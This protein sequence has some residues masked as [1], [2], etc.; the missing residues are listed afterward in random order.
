M[1]QNIK[2][3]GPEN[4]V[5]GKLLAEQ[6]I[7]SANDSITKILQTDAE[8][9]AIQ[10]LPHLAILLIGN[11]P[12]SELYVK[13]KSARAKE[14]GIETS[15]YKFP[16][17]TKQS[18]I[19]FLIDVLNDDENINGIMIQLPL[20]KNFGTDEILNRVAKIKDVDG[21][22]DNS[23]FYPATSLAI[24]ETL[25]TITQELG[26]KIAGKIA[27]VIGASKDV[28][29]PTQKL[30]TDEKV[31]STMVDKSWA[32]KD[33]IALC[34]KSDIVITATGNKFLVEKNWIKNGAIVIDVGIT[35][36]GTTETGKAILRGDA[37]IENIKTIASAITPVVG[38]IGPVTISML[39]KNVIT[40][41]QNQNKKLKQEK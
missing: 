7:A 22:A 13:T 27:T 5:N 41:Y 10:K 34:Q 4:I 15:L 24:M 9:N 12:A 29:Q 26:I 16:S 40:A 28:G 1:T 20:P 3:I 25:H 38:G 2:I 33:I 6:I 17:D 8:N 23:D 39:M 37:D 31:I 18:E 32:Q 36:I 21:T 11:D 14:L 35:R 19:L 30:L